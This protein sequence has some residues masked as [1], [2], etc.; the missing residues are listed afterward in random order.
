[1][2]Q[3]LLEER[4]KL[5]FHHERKEMPVY[6][7]TVGEK[8]SKMKASAPDAAL[9]PE[10]PWAPPKYVIGKDA[11]PVFPA[12]HGGVAGTSGNYRW[13]GVNVSMPEIVKTF[14]YYLGRPVVD[15]TGLTGKYDINI[16]WSF[17]MAWIMKPGLCTV[18][19]AVLPG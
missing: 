4:L 3:K 9:A 6:E 19:D 5:T 15:A 16:T 14:S 2:Q 8:G 17:D 1:M 7:L 13:T 18:P 11:F 12:G 10:D